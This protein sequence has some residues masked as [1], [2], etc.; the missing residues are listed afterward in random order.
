MRFL[1][2]FFP[3]LLF[4]LAY[5]FY[6]IFV[7]TGVAIAASVVQVGYYWYQH[8]RFEK[9]H[10]VSL[11]LIVVLGGLTILLR[12]K[13][14]IMWK[15]TLINW[16]FATAFLATQLVGKRTLV[17]RML[18]GKLS[19]APTIWRRLN[20]LWVA[21]FFLAGAANI[22][23]AQ[24]YANAEQALIAAI[25]NL[26][27][28][29]IDEL[30]CTAETYGNLI[31]LCEDAHAKEEIW[32]NFKLFG[33]LALTVLFVLAQALYLSR[34]METDESTEDISPKGES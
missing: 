1:Y 6:G 23:F 20:M 2:D 13:S 17:E 27:Q 15:P 12:D 29:E 31:T 16:L 28:Q 18:S 30:N 22:V 10:L 32:V 26:P 24:S 33:L 8:R 5:K 25:P 19:L 9:M 4:F 11:T 14:F 21:F 34:H 3:I 7:A